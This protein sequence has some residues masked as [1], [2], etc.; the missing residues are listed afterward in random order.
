[1]E[2]ETLTS[3]FRKVTLGG[4]QTTDDVIRH[5]KESGFF[6]VSE[7]INQRNFP[8]KPHEIEDI[9]IEIID[10]GCEFSEMEGI[11]FLETAGLERPT[12]EH[13]L[14][15][16][17][18][19]GNT[20]TGKKPFIVFLHEPWIDKYRNRRVLFIYRNPD[21]RVLNLDYTGLVFR[22]GRV[23]AGIRPRN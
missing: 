23:L 16:A 1:M 2:N 19:Y 17:E 4:P 8:L 7:D 11:K 10:P 20:T 6:F 15:F 3:H 9:Q 21:K 22:H 13:A 5:L 12:Y 18:Q 14:R